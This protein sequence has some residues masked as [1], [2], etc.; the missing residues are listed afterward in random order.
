MQS[1]S[2]L[3]SS[4]VGDW[5]LRSVMGEDFRRPLLTGTTSYPDLQLFQRVVS[6]APWIWL[7]MFILCRSRYLR[8]LLL[9]N[10]TGMCLGPEV[11]SSGCSKERSMLSRRVYP[12]SKNQQDAILYFQFISIINPYM[13]RAGLLLVIRRF[14]TVYTAVGICHAFMLMIEI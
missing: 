5:H 8:L 3:T 12:Y 9:F 1:V 14:Y 6:F 4:G 11:K 10:T 13:F 7:L 2:K